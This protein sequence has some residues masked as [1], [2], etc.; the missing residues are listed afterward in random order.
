MDTPYIVNKKGI[1]KARSLPVFLLFLLWPFALLVASLWQFRRPSA[2][3]GFILFCTYFG[4]V[5]IISQ[6]IGGADSARYAMALADMHELTPSFDNLWASLYSSQTNYVDIYQPLLTWI[7]SLFTAD[8]HYLFAMFALV[9]GIF[10][11]NNLWIILNRFK[12]KISIIAVVFILVLTLIIPI[13]YI[14]GVRMYTAAHIFIYGVL[15]YLCEEKRKGLFWSAV[16]ILVHFSFLFPVALLFSF[17]LL[18]KKMPVFFAFFVVT[19]FISEV[20]L[21]S[22]R[23]SLSFL[24]EIFQDRLTIYTNTDY[25]YSI[26]DAAKAIAWYVNFSG[27]ALRIAVYFLLIVTIITSRRILTKDRNLYI[28]FCFA[29]FFYG[30]ANIASLVPSGARF[31]AVANVISIATLL[32]YFAKY[33]LNLS[34]KIARV[35]SLPLIIFYCVFSI[36]VGFDFM[37]ISAL[38]GNPFTAMLIEDTKPLIEFVKSMFV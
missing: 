14:N 11:A 12:G 2:K 27:L 31:V 16:S 32:F 28:L 36:R 30:W 37:G 9:F 24:P 10:Y 22:I 5:F 6:D 8:A 17:V 20:D 25:A 29:L 4:F 21:F 13:W 35:I 23:S 26:K 3:M 34:I 18:P 7:I 33:K 38:L 19:I 1:T 15:L